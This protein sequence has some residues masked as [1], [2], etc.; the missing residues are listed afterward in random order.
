MD[1][2]VPGLHRNWICFLGRRNFVEKFNAKDE[3]ISRR[4][5]C[6]SPVF[7]LNWRQKTPM[8]FFSLKISGQKNIPKCCSWKGLFE[9]VNI[10]KEGRTQIE[11]SRIERETLI[12]L[13]PIFLSAAE[14]RNFQV[15]CTFF[16]SGLTIFKKYT[17]V[18]PM[19][20]RFQ[21]LKWIWGKTLSKGEIEGNLRCFTLKA[22]NLPKPEQ[23]RPRSTTTKPN[24][25]L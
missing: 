15:G 3:E 25:I 4:F 1:T 21:K 13:D 23:M 20:N 24:W 17:T 19:S 8:K 5:L 18:I 12:F 14:R 11:L 16:L 9:Y 10:F 2:G 6:F 22:T 7:I